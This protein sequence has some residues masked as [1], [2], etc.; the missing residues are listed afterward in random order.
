MSPPPVSVRSQ[1]RHRE[2]E[3][4]PC[5]ALAHGDVR[6]Q[7]DGRT[8]LGVL[9]CE[10]LH[11][12]LIIAS[13]A[14]RPPAAEDDVGTPAPF[15]GSRDRRIPCRGTRSPGVCRPGDGVWIA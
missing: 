2:W 14:V 1:V 7:D 11:R 3:S 12:L 8:Q 5:A 6:P 15:D 10:S 9:R 4:R 13:T